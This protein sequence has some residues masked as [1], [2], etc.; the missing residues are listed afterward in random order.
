MKP[1]SLLKACGIV[2][3]LA[4]AAPSHADQF[5]PK[6][7][8]QRERVA[9]SQAGATAPGARPNVPRGDLRG[10]IASNARARNDAQRPPSYSNHH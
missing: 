9:R 6:Q 4:L 10:D 7:H 3:S 5:P 8:E 2:V 1:M